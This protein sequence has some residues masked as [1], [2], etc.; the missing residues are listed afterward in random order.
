[1]LSGLNRTPSGGRGLR[2]SRLAA[3]SA[4]ECTGRLDFKPVSSAKWVNIKRAWTGKI[5]VQI[6]HDT[7]HGCTPQ[8]I[9]WW[10]ENLGRTTTW[11]GANFDGPKVSFYHL[12]HHRDHVA[13]TALDP[14]SA[15]FSV[16]TRTRIHER[17]NDYNEEIR[18]EVTTER[19]DDE[20][21]TFTGKLLGQ[22]IVKV[23]HLYSPEGDGSRFYAETQTG[24]DTPLLGWLFNWL[25]L[26]RVYS[27]RTGEHWIR[28]NV[29][30]TGRSEGVIPAL[31][32]HHAGTP[33]ALKQTSPNEQA[34]TAG[35]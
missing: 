31:Y 7:V 2:A 6:E 27:R 1:M 32:R 18:V 22:Q 34:G 5:C 16:G 10:F 23:I 29:E 33:Q 30:E 11:N 8:M 12:W 3:R 14:G 20:E 19:L 15:G 9:R 28:H 26:P 13:V 21:F 24:F 35:A 4:L 17:F 25:L